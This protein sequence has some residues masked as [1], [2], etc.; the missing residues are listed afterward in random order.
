M[1]RS[2]GGFSLIEVLV[3]ALVLAFGVIG[4]IGMQLTALRTT[5]QSIFHSS[6]LHL[7]ADMA[8][9][10][11]ANLGRMQT[12]DRDNPYLQVDF[13][14]GQSVPHSDTECYD[15]RDCDPR[16]IAQL[17]IDAWLRRL[18]ETLPD[19]RVR[20]CRDIA[21]WHTADA[22]FS[23]DCK[24]TGP[25]APVLIKIGWRDKDESGGE[26]RISSPR[27]ALPVASFAQ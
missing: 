15:P 2:E 10:M 18:A 7:A 5:Q 26:E 16:Q 23:W 19:A 6:A 9:R 11:R 24:E 8:D 22:S 14:A 4:A 25:S 13:A 1:Q 3:A 20:I 12:F 21:P 27:I 17:E